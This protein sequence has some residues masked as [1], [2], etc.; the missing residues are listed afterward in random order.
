LVAD[1]EVLAVIAQILSALGVANYKIRFS[2]R[3]LLNAVGEWCGASAEQGRAIYRVIDKLDKFDRQR[4][5][6]E[7]GS[8][9]TDQSGDKIPGLGLSDSQITRIDQFL[10]LPNDGD[11]AETLAAAR[12]L[13]AGNALAEEGLDEIADLAG[14][15]DAFGLPRTAW[16]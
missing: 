4:I 5:R 10:D 3:K 14:Y 1:A 9:L 16:M 13:L 15:L 6:M 8:G 7:L 2:N 12:S 11:M